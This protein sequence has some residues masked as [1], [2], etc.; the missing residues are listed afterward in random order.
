MNSNNSKKEK[1]HSKCQD[2][3]RKQKV[4]VD[5]SSLHEAASVYTGPEEATWRGRVSEERE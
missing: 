5:Q 2:A 3:G 4:L 1:G